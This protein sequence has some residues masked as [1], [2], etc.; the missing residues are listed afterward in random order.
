MSRL[1]RTLTWAGSLGAAAATAHSLV[2]LRSLRV[3]ADDP[4]PVRERVSVLVPARDEASRIGPCLAAVLDQVNV[5][6]LE[7]LVLD[8]GSSDGTAPAA[9]R[10]AGGDP[11]VRV[12]EGDPLP[13]GWLG[14]A[15]ACD[16]LG[17]AATGSVLIF[18]DADVVLAPHALAATVHLLRETGLDVA[19]PYP[20]QLA[21]TWSTLLPLRVAEGSARPSL[22]A[23]NGQLMALD[24]ETYRRIGGHRAVRAEVLDDV[25]LVRAVKA[26]GGRGGVV[27]GSWLATCRMYEDWPSLREGYTKSAWAAFGPPAAAAAVVA[28]LGVLYV[29]PPLAALRGSLVGL[30]GYGAAVAGRYVV[31]ERT[32]GRSLPDS[33]AHPASVVLLA[34]LTAESWARRRRGTLRWKGRPLPPESA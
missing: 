34:W 16:Q 30:A 8:D 14:K 22:T 29:V 23:G 5:P 27:D 19:S 24:A 20:R 2:N 25:A 26:G 28:G 31:A 13:Q 1:W 32:G 21:E 4:A 15:Y 17:R 12:L 7:I 9:R 33:F 10:A 11:R 3:P 18:L 6:D